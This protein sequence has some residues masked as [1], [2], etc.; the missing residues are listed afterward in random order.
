LYFYWYSRIYLCS[1]VSWIVIQIF[2][3]VTM[4]R[5]VNNYILSKGRIIIILRIKQSKKWK[6]SFVRLRIEESVLCKTPEDFN[7]QYCRK[8]LKFTVLWQW[9]PY[10]LQKWKHVKLKKSW[11]SLI[12][13][14]IWTVLPD[15]IIHTVWSCNMKYIASNVTNPVT[16]VVCK[17]IFANM[18]TM[19]NLKFAILTIIPTEKWCSWW[20]WWWWWR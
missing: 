17:R 9:R 16:S 14:I 11:Y 7:L 12:P 4:F 5:L 1:D 2:S 10:Q 19:Y 13:Y 6:W 3:D 20:R 15:C 8:Q 18:I